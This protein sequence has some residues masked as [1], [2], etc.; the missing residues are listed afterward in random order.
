[1]TK[2][3]WPKFRRILLILFGLEALFW[4]AMRV[5]N[6]LTLV[7]QFN[8]FP[9][10]GPFQTFNPLRRIAAG[11]HGG[12]DFQFFHGLGIPYV[13]YP[14]YA[15]G[16]K[17]IFSAELSRYSVSLAFFLIALLAIL[18][19]A[20]RNVLA[21]II[22][23]AALLPLSNQYEALYIPGNSLLGVRST[24]PVLFAAALILPM[25]RAVR[26]IVTAVLIAVA[27]FLGTEHGL[28]L[29]AAFGVMQLL[30]A[31]KH[32][33][34]HQLL[35]AVAGI[36]AG[37]CGYV[38]ILIAIGGP[39]GC[40]NALRF[41]FRSLPAD[42]F[43]Y[44]GSPPNTFLSSWSQVF[45]DPNIIP[46]FG[47][48]I[49][50]I[51]VVVALFW[52]SFEESD[53]RVLHAV[54]FFVIY[55][56]I[57][58]AAYL[59]IAFHGYFLPLQRTMTFGVGALAAY[60]S[61]VHAPRWPPRV[62]RA[63]TFGLYIFVAILVAADFWLNLSDLTVLVMPRYQE[64]VA[65]GRRTWFS[66]RWQWDMAASQRV[67]GFRPGMGRASIWS[68]YSGLVED[69]YGVFNPACD[70]IIHALGPEDRRTYIE[71]FRRTRPENVQTL[72]RSL[73]KYEE[74]V[75]DMH[76]DF[77]GDLLRD[78]RIAGVTSHS[79]W[80]KRGRRTPLVQHAG[81]AI[82]I[83]RER[84]PV[85]VLL[86][87]YASQYAVA[88]VSLRYHIHNPWARV[89][90]AGQL[91]RHLVVVSGAMNLYPI[92]LAPY[93]TEA[94]VP[95][96]LKQGQRPAI[97]IETESLT[98]G[99]SVTIDRASV[100]VVELDSQNELLVAGP[101]VRDVTPAAVHRDFR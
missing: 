41:A 77:Y 68:T 15:L 36:A 62:R 17:T 24:V 39:A 67:I 9:G 4:I 7:I 83:V 42:Q 13:L 76:W 20:S 95:I 98:P 50:I 21:T 84:E 34:F 25:R 49:P 38:L 40:R 89:P 55:G 18:Y 35:D 79:L 100:N 81:T 59:G 56:L 86:P 94:E 93:R 69:E 28:A 2:W 33:S 47:I 12:H 6:A 22:G 10:D 92:A 73:F 1:M 91:P 11:Q 27:L 16:G 26:V 30:S 3:H 97:S 29:I 71:T 53:E 43:W 14:I 82:R 58:C 60:A 78:Y 37:A 80:W 32:R 101:L 57:T 99:T 65:M 87:P 61:V 45:H 74:W 90:I 66:Q 63:A 85:P 54:A 46:N 31:W 19:A 8:G 52:R 48:A 88:V 64:Y 75:R 72:G 44:F 51:L 5:A 70:Y 23:A 96:F